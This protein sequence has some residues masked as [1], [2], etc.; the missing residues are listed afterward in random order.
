MADLRIGW[1][2]NVPE[3]ETERSREDEKEGEK[4]KSEVICQSR[5]PAALNGGS[6]D[7]APEG[8]GKKK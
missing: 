7:R 4:T 1:R 8:N 3:H 2:R 6:G 5:K